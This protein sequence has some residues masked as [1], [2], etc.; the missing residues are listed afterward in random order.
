MLQWHWQGFKSQKRCK[1]C[2]EGLKQ[3]R[4]QIKI[5]QGKPA[6]DPSLAKKQ[7]N[8]KPHV[9]LKKWGFYYISWK[10]RPE[11]L[12]QDI[13]VCESF[14]HLQSPGLCSCIHTEGTERERPW[15][16]EH[17]GGPRSWLLPAPRGGAVP[18][19]QRPGPSHPASGSR[20][21][22]P[23]ELQQ[24]GGAHESNGGRKGRKDGQNGRWRRGGGQIGLG[25]CELNANERENPN[26]MVLLPST[27]DKGI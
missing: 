6:E 25:K 20:L 19:G 12:V 22:C 23:G 3:R 15:V 10:Q 1:R 4:W 17:L 27:G 8:K 26:K 7:T 18:G 9:A 21:L 16:V 13:S 2:P 24:H 5:P 11:E 14:P